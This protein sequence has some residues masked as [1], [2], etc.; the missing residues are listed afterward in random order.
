MNLDSL[1]FTLSQISYLV[2]NL[3]KKNFEDSCREISDVSIFAPRCSVCARFHLWLSFRNPY[4]LPRLC[5]VFPPMQDLPKVLRELP[6]PLSPCHVSL[7]WSLRDTKRDI[8]MSLVL[9]TVNLSL[10]HHTVSNVDMHTRGAM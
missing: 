8:R 3:S 9:F 1:S 6:L 7:C 2:A 10:E 4:P 5:V